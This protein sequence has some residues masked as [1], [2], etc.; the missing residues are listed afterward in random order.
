VGE[1]KASTTSQVGDAIVAR[2]VARMAAG[3]STG[4]VVAS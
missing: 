1:E 2:F 4:P 3:K